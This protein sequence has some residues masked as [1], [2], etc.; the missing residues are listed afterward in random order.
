MMTTS[1]EAIFNQDY[2]IFKKHL[3]LKGL[4]ESTIDGYSRGLRRI[5][6]HFDFH[7]YDLTE[8]QLLD[9]FV[10]L[11]ITHSHS[12]LKLDFYGLKFFYQHVLKKAWDCGDLI[13][14]PRVQKIPNILTVEQ[15][16]SLFMSTRVASYRVFYFTVY[17]LGL[18]ISEG[19]N[20]KV[21][22]IDSDRMRVHIRKGKGR[23]DRFVPLP[24]ATLDVLRRFWAIH[25]N[26]VLLFPS[27]N[28]GLECSRTTTK[29]LDKASVSKALNIVAT[30]AGIKKKITMHSLRHCYATHLIESGVD[31]LEVQKA[32]GHASILTTI[33]YTHLTTQTAKNTALQLN[34]LMNGFSITWGNVK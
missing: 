16:S 21:G 23:K 11:L 15:A 18:R 17:S 29:T 27:R 31:L 7:I 26:P 12:S 28:G 10:D 13:K 3:K 34:Q 20:L 1:L 33:K 5:S 9:Y 22:D 8:H 19:V 6:Q 32:L 25:R 2:Q 24:Q 4:E 30:D 14:S